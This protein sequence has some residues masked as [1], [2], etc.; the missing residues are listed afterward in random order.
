MRRGRSSARRLRRPGPPHRALGL[1][2]P[3]GLLRRERRPEALPHQAPDPLVEPP[4]G[5][6]LLRSAPA[7]ALLP[8]AVPDLF[9]RCIS[10]TR[11]AIECLQPLGL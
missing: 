2:R 6:L 10:G 1:L 3:T 7:S 5:G 8:R 11:T 9:L 4:S